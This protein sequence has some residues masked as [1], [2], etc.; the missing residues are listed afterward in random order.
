MGDEGAL[1]GARGTKGSLTLTSGLTLGFGPAPGCA[2]LA[3]AA[4]AISSIFALRLG[5]SG[6][7]VCPANA[8]RYGSREARKSATHSATAGDRRRFPPPFLPSL[9]RPFAPHL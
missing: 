9:S 3:F 5:G 8:S 6:G 7:S 1:P 2:A 4:R